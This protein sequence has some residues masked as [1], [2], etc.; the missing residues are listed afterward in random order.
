VTTAFCELKKETPM[1]GTFLVILALAAS[2]SGCVPVAIGA[3]AAIVADE[4]IEDKKGG[5]GLF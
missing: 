5:D 1:R 2:L 3:G 4:V